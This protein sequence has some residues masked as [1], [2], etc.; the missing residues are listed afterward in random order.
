MRTTPMYF[1][2]TKSNPPSRKRDVCIYVQYGA[3]QY[4]ANEDKDDQPALPC[5][6]LLRAAVSVSD[7]RF[8]IQG[9]MISNYLRFRLFLN[10]PQPTSALPM[11][12]NSST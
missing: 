5:V 7:L 3:S 6:L 9:Y 2:L 8:E 10:R 4:D 1:H 12:K 11:E